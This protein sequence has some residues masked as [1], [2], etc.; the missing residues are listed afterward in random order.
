MHGETPFIALELLHGDTLEDYLLRNNRISVR[1]VI[2][3]GREIATGLG[4]AHARGLL[5]RDIKP[6][7]IWLERPETPVQE[8][9]SAKPNQGPHAVGLLE[10]NGPLID[11][12]SAGR[13]KILDFGL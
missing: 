8:H 10:P 11:R 7:N 4:A 12:A 6:A 9:L 3:I 1:E 2:R 13:V 5:H